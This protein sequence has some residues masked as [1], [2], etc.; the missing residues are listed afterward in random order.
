MF[1][2]GVAPGLSVL[3][4]A[5]CCR[6]QK[7]YT[8]CYAAVHLNMT[9]THWEWPLQSFQHGQ[10]GREGDITYDRK[11]SRRRIAVIR[12]M[13]SLC[14]DSLVTLN[15][16]KIQNCAMNAMSRL[17]NFENKA[18]ASSRVLRFSPI[19]DDMF[20]SMCLICALEASARE[21]HRVDESDFSVE[22]TLMSVFLKKLLHLCV[23][24]AKNAGLQ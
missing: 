16:L 14:N 8:F 6:L 22:S 3:F 11:E 2:P 4:H 15:L 21:L 13:S 1:L 9:G 24:A 20:Q 23:E 19:S 18:A 10:I 12:S 5:V 7:R 17:P